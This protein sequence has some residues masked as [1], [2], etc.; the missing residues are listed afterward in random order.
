MLQALQTRLLAI[1][2]PSGEKSRY[3][4]TADVLQAPAITE[5]WSQAIGLEALVMDNAVMIMQSSPDYLLLIGEA[6]FLNVTFEINLAFYVDGSPN[7][8]HALLLA[9]PASGWT[10]LNS[11]PDLPSYFN[12]AQGSSQPSFFSDLGL[13]TPRL[14]ISSQSTEVAGT[15]AKIDAILKE[16]GHKTQPLLQQQDQIISGLNFFGELTFEEA[17]TFINPLVEVA[18]LK[19]FNGFTKEADG[20]TNIHLFVP[21]AS[22]FEVGGFKAEFQGFE[23]YTSTTSSVLSSSGLVL[24]GAVEAG[25]IQINIIGNVP[26]G[27]S[28]ASVTAELPNGLSLANITS[29]VSLT[30]MDEMGDL[31][32][33]P[34]DILAN[35][36]LNSFSVAFFISSPAIESI[37]FEMGVSNTYTF[38]DGVIGLEGLR[39]NGLLNKPFA[40]TA[41]SRKLQFQMLAIW[42]LGTANI[43]TS[44]LLPDGVLTGALG[45][46]EPLNLSDLF[47]KFFPGL[48]IDH[49]ILV[50]DLEAQATKAGAYSLSIEMADLWQL[51]I[52]DALSLELDQ[53]SLSIEGDKASGASGEMRAVLDVSGIGIFISAGVPEPGGGWLFAGG[54]APGQELS[55]GDLITG[56]AAKFGVDDS[57]P[58]PI[59]AFTMQDIFASFDTGAKTFIFSCKGKLPLDEDTV[60]EATINVEIT[61]IQ[62]STPTAYSK[63]FTGRITIDDYDFAL[64]FSSDPS[65]NILAAVLSIEGDDAS[66]SIQSLISQLSPDAADAIPELSVTLKQAAIIYA[67]VQADPNTGQPAS[68]KTLFTVGLQ[69]GMD[70]TNLP[71]VGP[72]L[73]ASASISLDEVRIMY[74]KGGITS[75][76]V[77]SAFTTAEID[78]T[79]P[80]VGLADGAN[81]AGTME[82]GP[83]PLQFDLPLESG[84]ASNGSSESNTGGSSSTGGSTSKRLPAPDS[85][86]KWFNINKRLGPL[87]LARIGIN[88]A[89]SN[90]WFMADAELTLGP[91]TLSLLELS[92]GSPLDRFAPAFNL[93]GFGLRYASGPVEVGGLF[94]RI[95][96]DAGVDP[97]LEVSDRFGGT[98]VIKTSSLTIAA[99]GEYAMVNGEPSFYIFAYLG[100][101]LG[102]PAFFFV[103]GLAA[104]FGYNRSVRIPDVSQVAQHPMIVVATE[105]ID[106]PLDLAGLLISGNYIPINL[107]KIFLAVGIRFTS[108]KLIDSF[109]LVIATFGDS[110]R[111]DIMGRSKLV[112]PTADPNASKAVTPLAEITLLLRGSFV[113]DE[114][115]LGIQAQLSNDSY[116]LSRDC[117]LQ[118]GFAF[119]TWFDPSPYAGDFVLTLGGYHPRFNK[120]AHYPNVP[121]LGFNWRVTP[122]LTIKGRMYMALTPSAAM[123]GGSLE[124]VWKD[125]SLK[126]SFLIGADFLISWKPYHYDAQIYV[127]MSISYTFWFFGEHTVSLSIGADLH[128]WGPE[129]SGV[130]RIDLSIVSFT[131]EFGPTPLNPVQ[132][133]SWQEFNDSFLPAANLLT[134]SIA[135]GLLSTAK[136]ETTGAEI[137]VINPKTFT[138]NTDSVLPIEQGMYD[139]QAG[140][141]PLFRSRNTQFGIS[142][143]GLGASKVQ[144]RASLAVFNNSNDDQQGYFRMRPIFKA[145]P[146]ALWGTTLSA[147]LNKEKELVHNVLTGFTLIARPPAEAPDEMAWAYK[148]GLAFNAAV[149]EG[150]DFEW[151]DITGANTAV[152]TAVLLAELGLS[153]IGFQ[154]GGADKVAFFELSADPLYR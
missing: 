43:Y 99:L 13:N 142:P 87:N 6:A 75:A 44:L 90:L 98:A 52:S 141:Q 31:L 15:A 40:S 112:L 27:G 83:F 68:G 14:L 104:G 124:A 38:I 122:Q 29:L 102:G 9:K 37:E 132:P 93:R 1:E 71:L 49:D 127:H 150:S 58:E 47:N 109:V 92:F 148:E 96:N 62:N 33:M 60:L 125:G 88:F 101:P 147:G 131:V 76:D 2:T 82:L 53:L 136:E 81:I 48:S 133:I 30:N 80:D 55:I 8:L 145:V 143:M 42:K 10:I 116:I 84:S 153:D 73:P 24:Y 56:L 89:D 119:F 108:F 7:A 70:F 118:G 22:G 129:F 12:L 35:I 114:G 5:S 18:E 91:L 61:A 149:E 100:Y 54:T 121:R 69:L 94:L 19:F 28:L 146:R 21:V 65:Q 107:G 4:I 23:L 25:D 103:E 134:L 105:G 130:A 139:D 17:L 67:S 66:V 77:S 137:W 110:F 135:D 39:F 144:T 128:V 46:E 115:F 106:N 111:L 152:D 41:N 59:K 11:F 97:G 78:I 74:S 50:L 16:L 72:M 20:L 85:P 126:A 117:T 138:M 113:P 86:G 151:Q 32:P 51:S 123:A 120:P 3:D 79:L 64:L 140:L 36:S 45:P 26:I 57:I 95:D 154:D 63:T 34:V